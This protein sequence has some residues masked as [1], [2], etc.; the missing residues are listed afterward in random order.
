MWLHGIPIYNFCT[1]KLIHTHK[2]WMDDE[3]WMTRLLIGDDRFEHG[4]FHQLI[5]DIV[6]LL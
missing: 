6:S 5:N 3:S 4:R 2:P 1:H